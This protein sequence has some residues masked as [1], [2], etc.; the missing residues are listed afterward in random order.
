MRDLTNDIVIQKNQNGLSYL[1]F[2]VLLNLVSL[3]NKLKSFTSI[4]NYSITSVPKIS[5]YFVVKRI[6]RVSEI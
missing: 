5:K 2:K 3:Y 4:L 1:Q 6:S